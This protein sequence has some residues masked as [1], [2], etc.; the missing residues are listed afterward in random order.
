MVLGLSQLHT[1]MYASLRELVDGWGKNIY[2][3]GRDAA[4]FGALGRALYPA[5]LVLPSL[6]WILPPILLA[7]GLAG[8]VGPGVSTWA[9]IVSSVNL[10]WW[11]LVYAA[12]R[13]SPL[14]ALLHPLGAAVVLYISLRAIVRGRQ[15]HWKGRDYQV[16]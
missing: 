8:M 11:V 5:L 14:Y 9:V 6:T 15:V 13:M 7:L 10:L 4:P 3:G 16:A 12:L 2:A 1:R